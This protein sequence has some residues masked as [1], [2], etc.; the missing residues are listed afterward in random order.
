MTQNG[1]LPE[2]FASLTDKNHH[3]VIKI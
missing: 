3:E 1:F 2:N